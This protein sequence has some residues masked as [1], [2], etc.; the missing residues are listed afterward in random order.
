MSNSDPVQKP[1]DRLL[2]IM[3]T[4]RGPNGCPWDREQNHKSIQPE[5]LEECYEVLEA[6]DSGDMAHLKEELGD[7][8]LQVVF[9]S[10]MAREAGYFGFD[11]VAT[12]ISDKLVRRHP[13]VWGDVNAPDSAAVLK[14]WHEIKKTEKPDRSGTFSGITKGLP[15][16]V[17]ATKVQKKAANAGFDWPDAKGP[18]EKIKEETAELEKDLAN[19]DRAEEELGDLLFAV[20]NLSRHLKID[21][22]QAMRRAVEKFRARY[23]N[24]EAL[25]QGQGQSLAGMTPVEMDSFWAK[26]K[27]L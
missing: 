20:V 18:L 12:S 4:L 23:E 16:L 27:S 6:I 14:N 22:E 10:Q 26:A 13:H 19:R 17:Y 7:L 1:I 5:L 15:A 9:H 21:A 11:D 24:M 25:A 2:E 3:A 8:L